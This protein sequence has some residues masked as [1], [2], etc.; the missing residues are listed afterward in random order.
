MK[1]LYRQG[2]WKVWGLHLALC[3]FLA[4]PVTALQ[5]GLHPWIMDDSWKALLG[6]NEIIDGLYLHTDVLGAR[7]SL[8]EINGASGVTR[9]QL[10]M[11]EQAAIE[12]LQRFPTA[13]RPWEISLTF[14]EGCRRRPFGLWWRKY[15]LRSVPFSV[16]FSE[17]YRGRVLLEVGPDRCGVVLDDPSGRTWLGECAPSCMETL[18]AGRHT[19]I[20]RGEAD[21][22]AV[23]IDGSPCAAVA[24]DPPIEALVIGLESRVNACTAFDDVA[25]RVEREAGRWT[26]LFQEGFEACP[27]QTEAIDSI[28][29]LDGKGGRVVITW[30]IL[31]AALLLDLAALALFGRNGPVQT[32]LMIAL[33]QALSILALQK[34]LLF[35]LAPL[36]FV[37]AVLWSSKGLLA[38]TGSPPE[39][40]LHPSSRARGL[41]FWLSLFALQT[42][43]G[44]WFMRIWS[45]VE[46]E[47]FLVR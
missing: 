47:T 25:V 6:S 20:L 8:E 15:D 35:P 4:V 21:S 10:V 26:P 14:E 31:V 2:I 7:W 12:T 37:V 44:L 19:L 30:A 36:F 42:V 41:A 17:S 24:L 22:V 9:N 32:L 40:R 33:P 13:G 38:F 29:S 3:L 11:V 1:R 28:V 46:V 27:F 45:F 39:N 18:S 23:E 5:L 34:L 43:H 16:V